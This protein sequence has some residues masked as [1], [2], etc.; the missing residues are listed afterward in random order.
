MNKSHSKRVFIYIPSRYGSQ[1]L[2]AKALAPIKGRPLVSWVIDQAKGS[3]LAERVVV[4][5]D[6][7]RIQEVALGE[8]AEVQMTPSECPSGT[9]R[10]AWA[11]KNLKDRPDV[12]VNLQGDEPLITPQ[13]IDLAIAPVLNGECQ[14]ST[15]STRFKSLKEFESRNC[16]K[17][18]CRKN[19][20]AI[21]FSRFAIPY[22]RLD[23]ADEGSLIPEQ[24]IGLYVYETETLL[25]L[26]ALA[27][28]E[29]EK[30]ESL[31]QLR[32]LY[33]G[34]SIRVVE[35]EYNGVGVDT[36]EDLERVSELMGES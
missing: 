12:V 14:I 28:T 9:D 30:M 6:D 8:G 22:S 10:I 36:P 17:V 7:A 32:A 33:Y 29:L 34:Y 21:Y 26:A 27:P 35:T 16:V 1:R 20:D 2:P 11:V 23:P 18:L 4:V 31:E 24:H 3:K 13:A 5:T 19:R 25:K 15:L